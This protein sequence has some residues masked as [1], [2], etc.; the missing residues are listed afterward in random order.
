M[1]AV[2]PDLRGKFIRAWTDGSSYDPG[3]LFGS[4]QVAQ[5]NSLVQIEGAA[6]SVATVPASGILNIPQ[7]GTWSEWTET[8][9]ATS[10]SAVQKRF[11]LSGQESHPINI[12]L[13]PCI[14]Y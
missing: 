2:V 10:T 9:D 11:R 3:R 14:K 5:T 6:Y 13:L 7:D 1:G 8:G 12:S 4:V